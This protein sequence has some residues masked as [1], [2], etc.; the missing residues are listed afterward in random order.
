MRALVYCCLYTSA[1]TLSAC[2]TT[3]SGSLLT[4]GMSALISVGATGDDTTTVTTELFSGTPEQL[5]FVDLD[6]SDT[7]TATTQ[8]QTM[9]LTKGQ[10]ATI[11]EYAATFTG[12]DSGDAFVVSLKRTVDAGAPS[13]TATLPDTFTLGAAPTSQS[14][15]SALTLTWSPS[16]STDA[17]T[18]QASGD[19]IT[20]ASGTIAGDPGTVTIPAATLT[21]IQGQSTASCSVTMTVFRSRA[22][23]LDAHF[24]DGGTISAQQSRTATLTSTP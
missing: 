22:G 23:T 7:L 13:S 8:G 19:C 1:L 24:G 9:T 5:I 4:S 3:E 18:W 12:D 15:A 11:I 20:T 6:D 2:G 21:A 16:G 14:R 17:M 10:L